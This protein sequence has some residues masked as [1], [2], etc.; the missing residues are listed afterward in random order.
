MMIGGTGGGCSGADHGIGIAESGYL[1][2]SSFGD[3]L[4]KYDFGDKVIN[5]RSPS[6]SYSLNLWIR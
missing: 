6:Q 2:H 1:G 5:Q 4:W 3:Y